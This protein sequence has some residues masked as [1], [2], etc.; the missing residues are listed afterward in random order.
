[1]AGY[2]DPNN[3]GNSS[4]HWTGKSCIEPGCNRPAGTA[5]GSHWCWKHNVERL[6]RIEGSLAKMIGKLKEPS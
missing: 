2:D 1:M 4:E 6:D 5:W 3:E